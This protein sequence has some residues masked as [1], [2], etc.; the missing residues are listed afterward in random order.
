MR[1]LSL[2]SHRGD[3]AKNHGKFLAAGVM[4]TIDDVAKRAGVSKMTVS[5][6]INRSGYISPETRD[7]VERVVAELG[8]VPNTL[9]RSLRFKQTKTVALVLTDITNP[10][11]TTVARGVEDTA[12]EQGFSVMFCN[13]DESQTEET[14]YL[15][16]LLQKQVDGVLLVPAN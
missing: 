10:F 6:V 15:N 13:T 3:S 5:R 7:R 9:A 8:Y 11:F 14:E 1:N 12:S 16:V 4:S 2:V